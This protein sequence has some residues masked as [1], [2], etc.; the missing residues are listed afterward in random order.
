MS[1]ITGTVLAIER[2]SLH[3]G[4]GIRSTVFLKGCPL[5]CLWCHNPE[6]QCFHSELSFLDERC[7]RC[8]IC[9]TTCT[10]G[11]HRIIDGVHHLDREACLRC[12]ACVEACPHQ[13]LE[14]KGRS[15]SVAMVLE[16]VGKDRAYYAAS[17]GGM[18]IS[19]G[20]PTAQ[21]DFCRALLQAAQTEGIHCCLETSAYAPQQR[22]LDLCDLVDLFLIDWKESDPQLHRRWTGVAQQPIAE[23]LLALDAAGARMLLRCPIVPGLNDRDDHFSGIAAL[24]N[25]LNHVVGIEIM[26][27]HPLGASKARSIG[28]DYPLLDLDFASREQADAWRRRLAQESEC[29][30]LGLER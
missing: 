6:S 8:G 19:G 12:G 24:A 7:R 9:V 23:N 4:P 27:Y 11:V 13:A 22:L 18:T 30:I 16:E 15:M 14:L 25:R 21:Y 26:P 20:E 3:D 1:A 17:Q 2:C 10:Q 29:E 28:R 5:S